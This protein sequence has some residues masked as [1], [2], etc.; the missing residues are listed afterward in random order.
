MSH[1]PS[2]RI[3]IDTTLSPTSP[4]Q[5]GFPFPPTSP[6]SHRPSSSSRYAPRRGSN[7]STLSVTSVGGSLDTS[8][9]SRR[10]STVRESTHQN[11]ISTLLHPPIVRT[12]LM[13]QTQPN[14][15]YRAP[16][17]RDIPPVTLT[18]IPHV[19]PETFRD[20]LARIGPLFDSFQR[21]RQ[22]E[23]QQKGDRE[24]GRHDRFAEAL[25]SRGS[26]DGSVSP[27]LR[28][29]HSAATLSP[30][31][32]P[33]P[34]GPRRRS[35]AQWRRGR[36]EPT[37]LNTIPNVYFDEDFH[38]EN[39][40]TFDT[41]SERAEIVRPP[42]GT[43]DKQANGAPQ[44]PRKS[45]ATNAILQEKLS[46]Y[47]DTVEVHLI[48]NIST[49]SSGFF[50]ALGSLKSLQNEAEESVAKIQ[51]LREDLR[52]LDE[53][54]AVRGLEVAAKKRKR[55]NVAKLARATQQVEQVVSEVKRADNLVDEGEY[56]EAVEQM[57]KVGRLASGQPEPSAEGQQHDLIDLRSLKAL[58]GLDSGLQELQYRIGA[59]FA[60][61]FTKILIDDLRQHVDRVPK[62][63]TLKRWSRQRGIPP[64]YMETDQQF[65][66]ALLSSLKGLGRAGHTAPAT[67]A[68][69]EAV[70][71]FMK[72]LIR[73][74]LPSSNDE[75]ADS[76]V[77]TSTRGG[78]KLTQQEKSSILARNLRAM[79][80][81]D[82]EGLLMSV[83]TSVG[84]ALRRVSTQTKVLLDVTS[85]MQPP[86]TNATS[87]IAS[88]P[89]SPG[90]PPKSPEMLSLDA[91]LAN[92]SAKANNPPRIAVHNTQQDVQEELSQAL[93]MSS[94]LGQAVD[95]AQNQITRVLKVRNEQSIRLPQ[96][97]FLRYFTLNRLFADECEAVS[98]RGSQALR[99]VIN[100]QISGFVQVMGTSEAEKVAGILDSDD[101]NA[102]DFTEADEKVL[103]KVLGSMSRDPPEW[104]E[105]RKAIWEDIGYSPERTSESAEVEAGDKAADTNGT[106]TPNTNGAVA[107][108]TKIASKPAYIDENRFILV[109]SA[110]Q[111]LP[112]L[113][114]FLSLTATL[115]SMTSSISSALLEVLKTFNSRSTQLILGAGATRSAGLKN[116][117]TKHLALASQALSFVIALV[118]YMR[119]CARRHLP[120]S[121]QTSILAEF[122][123]TKRV[124]QDHQSGI[125][126]K[127]VD[128]MT[129]TSQTHIKSLHTATYDKEGDDQEE[130]GEIDS[131]SPFIETLTKQ[132]L[133]FHRV[134]SR[135][136]SEFD[137]GLI[138]RRIAEQYREQWV[139]AFKA[140]EVKP[141]SAK[142]RGTKRLVKDAETFR[143]KLEK[144]EGFKEVGEEVLEVVRGKVG[145]EGRKDEGEKA[146]KG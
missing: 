54:V 60:S 89:K 36:N 113:D 1:A 75:D 2:P 24:D 99:G 17:T 125:H 22:E 69:R 70:Q 79:D 109:R 129:G 71:K 91:Q 27:T 7:A 42:P 81:Q 145:L 67:A 15:G 122:D 84:E 105:G 4:G 134:L 80:A 8:H 78:A 40:R 82:A 58:Q 5:T 61:R 3:S 127:L 146:V 106:S 76:M 117:T 16:T 107:T 94:L 83:Y 133:T 132:T 13:P 63:N 30:V 6:T 144:L 20:Y 18:N 112:T 115:P 44:P 121:G 123:K 28:R 116:I 72:E 92:G 56:E 23:D 131:P 98:G 93:D 64:T 141:N 143:A 66:T 118:P 100:A 136:L 53:E 43:V 139:T 31:E 142:R 12:G 62:E 57:E 140:I 59:G 55:A 48:N 88:P 19:A 73:K 124:Y 128:I 41:V 126:D 37:P 26:K 90:L 10:G 47:M 101:W 85:S 77:S 68:Y 110:I 137:V 39:P 86:P 25:E 102:K 34:G 74:H 11:A 46:W 87:P 32:T 33:T 51:G 38:L 50:Q 138:M 103:Q 35:S 29:Q 45:L 95:T 49:A 104:T 130:D 9:G 119:E 21:G 14:T 65:R 111:L 135:H 114:H 120:S 52:R 108:G 97:R 96:E